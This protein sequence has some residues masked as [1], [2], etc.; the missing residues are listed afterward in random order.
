MRTLLA[1]LM[2]TVVAQAQTSPQMISRV[3]TGEGCACLANG[4]SWP[5]RKVRGAPGN[6][7]ETVN[8]C[9]GGGLQLQCPE[10]RQAVCQYV[11][12]APTCT[13]PPLTDVCYVGDEPK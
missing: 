12:T 9:R 13:E 2:L 1:L 6:I 4:K 11:M 7:V 10:D 3:I 5:C 8:L